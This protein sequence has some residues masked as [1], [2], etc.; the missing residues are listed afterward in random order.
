MYVSNARPQELEEA[1]QE[2]CL[3]TQLALSQPGTGD[4]V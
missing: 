2:P 3:A 1:D 4:L